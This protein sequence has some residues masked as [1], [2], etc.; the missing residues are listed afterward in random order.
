MAITT[1]NATFDGINPVQNIGFSENWSGNSRIDRYSVYEPD[2]NNELVFN[3]SLTGSDWRV[4]SMGVFDEGGTNITN[5]T[6]LDAGADRRIE[7]LKVGWNSDISL[8][9]T[10]IDVLTS[11]DGAGHT[12]DVGGGRID[13]IRIGGDLNTITA[14]SNYSQLIEVW[15]GTTD[16]T[17]NSG[18]VE[19][20]NLAEGNDTVTV[21][22]GVTSLRTNDGNDSVTVNSSG[23]VGF[24]NT[25]D[26]DDSVLV[27]GGF[28]RALDTEDD[29]DIVTVINGGLINSA[30]T[31][32]GDDTLVLSGGS[33]IDQLAD[34]SGTTNITLSGNSRIGSISTNG[35]TAIVLN[36]TSKFNTLK[37]DQGVLNLTAGSAFLETFTGYQTTLDIDVE[38]IGSFTTFSDVA[39]SHTAIIRDY[40]RS[41]HVDDDFSDA[42]DDN[43]TDL[44]VDGNLEWANLGN[45]V[46]NVTVGNNGEIQ[47]Y[48]GG[49]GADNISTVDGRLGSIRTEGGEDTIVTGTEWTGYIEA[50]DDDDDVTIGD[51]GA[52][53]VYLGQGDDIV[54]TG[55]GWVELITTRDGN[56]TVEVGNGGGGTVRT[57]NGDDLIRVSD[58]DP[59]FGLA[60]S[61][62]S[63]QDALDFSNFSMGVSFR[64][65][66]AGQFQN[67]GAAGGDL[68]LPGVAGYFNETSVEN[69]VGSD[70]GDDLRG[71]EFENK[72]QG[73][74]GEDSLNGRLGD[75]KVLG[76]D[77]NDFLLGDDGMDTVN[78]GAGNDTLRGDD[79]D[80]VL[81]GGKNK[82]VLK[83][84]NGDDRIQ[85]DQ[86]GDWMNGGDGVD[87]FVFRAGSGW[88]KIFEFEQGIDVMEI[89]DHVGGFATLAISDVGTRLEIIHDGGRIFLL[90]EA[91]TTLSAAD[92]DFI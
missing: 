47:A 62:G 40:G 72:L 42:T 48:F 33:T 38:R 8:L 5:L 83:G 85:G 1:V 76:E 78:G 86:G 27:D 57:S 50:G 90:D 70:H 71:D 79:G 9:S 91:G 56:D 63:G 59:T 20:I 19:A 13:I 26:N 24:I 61:G 46:N 2:T 52:G 45:G 69:L 3:G 64:L 66:L 4:R 32:H 77:G 88:D 65:D 22:G 10:R 17:I 35:D 73:G 7:Y 53:T 80:D 74:D 54:R 87:T 58:T 14:G 75:D 39:L 51:G 25:R 49:R 89:H 36:D 18:G 34:W 43:N 12:I 67:V 84:G 6:D 23:S 92:F 30:V 37:V 82:D 21:N 11:D 41:F 55:N 60:V 15:R 81:F 68:S 44:T 16:L 28:V 31:N 29:D